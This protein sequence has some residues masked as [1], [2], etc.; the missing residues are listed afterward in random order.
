[1]VVG[2]GSAHA[3]HYVSADRRWLVTGP[4]AKQLIDDVLGSRGLAACTSPDSWK[5]SE[6]LV[7]SSH[8]QSLHPGRGRDL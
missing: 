3:A 2:R 7:T 8:E 1:M 6:D 5:D 4:P